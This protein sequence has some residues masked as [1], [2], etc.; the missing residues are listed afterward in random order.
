MK[1]KSIVP[2]AIRWPLL[3]AFSCVLLTEILARP[4]LQDVGLWMIEQPLQLV[5]N[6]LAVVLVICLSVAI[7]GRR[8]NGI[9]AGT[10][11]M[12]FMAL[13]NAVKL[14]AL[15]TPFFAW[16]LMYAR[17]MLALG[18]ALMSG[19]TFGWILLALLILLC[20]GAWWLQRKRNDRVSMKMRATLMAMALGGLGLFFTD[21]RTRLP[22]MWRVENIAWEQPV[23]YRTN[24]FFLAFS[25]NVS[26]MLIHQPEAYGEALVNRLLAHNE[27]LRQGPIGNRGKPVS[28]VILMSE[29]FS[30]LFGIP[31]QTSENPWENLQRLSAHHPSFTLISPTVAG[32]TSLVEFEA[33]TGLSHALL[34]SGSVPYDHYLQRQVPSIASILRDRGWSTLAV[35]PYEPWFWNRTEAYRNLGFDRFVSIDDFENPVKRGLFVSDDSMVDKMI[36][37]IEAIKGPYFMHAISMQNHGPHDHQRY[38]DDIVGVEGNFPPHLLESLSA[39][40]TGVRDADRQL[41]RFL[42]YLE[43]RPEPVICVFFGDHQPALGWELLAHSSDG[44]MSETERDYLM[45]TVPGLVWAN[46]PNLLDSLDIPKRFSPSHLPGL[47]LHQMGIELPGH[48]FHMWQGLKDYSVLHRRFV[49]SPAGNLKSFK[50]VSSAPWIKDLEILQYDVLFGK[51]YST[52]DSAHPPQPGNKPVVSLVTHSPLKIT[53]SSLVKMASPGIS[54]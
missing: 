1:T 32:N 45:A 49:G 46:K 30:D 36:E 42:K 54:R 43:S 29:S 13:I 22:G 34:P 41:A 31:F 50:Q 44:S 19:F 6:L 23:N 17:Q 10:G 39:F 52:H 2:I 40:L 7:T 38:L 37:L 20:I 21:L 24:G 14:T 33:L 18:E 16:D 48:F 11:L 9:I 47:L 51:G 26:P 25:M 27:E 5:L 3:I 53:D 4:H 12:L 15:Q 35:H 8:W 28:L